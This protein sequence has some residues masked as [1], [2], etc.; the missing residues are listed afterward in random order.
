M[1]GERGEFARTCM[2]SHFSKSDYDRVCTCASQERRWIGGL[3]SVKHALADMGKEYYANGRGGSPESPTATPPGS[4]RR[5]A[6]EHAL[7]AGQEGVDSCDSNTVSMIE[8]QPLQEK[9]G[10]AEKEGEGRRRITL[11]Q[12]RVRNT[13][14]LHASEQVAGTN[15]SAART[16]RSCH[17][18]LH[19]LRR[20]LRE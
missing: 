11:A 12:E 8:T 6:T 9:E 10:Q 16:Y 18:L 5:N 3:A 2:E 4:A 15:L 1:E 17:S 7:T 13:L 20:P 14:A 19:S